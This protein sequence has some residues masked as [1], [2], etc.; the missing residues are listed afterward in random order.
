MVELILHALIAAVA[1]FGV[2]YV[3]GM[4]GD[5]KHLLISK[6]KSAFDM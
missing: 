5:E 1:F 3:I 4:R 2:Y 6:I